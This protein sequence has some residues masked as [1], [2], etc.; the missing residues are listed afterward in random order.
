[1]QRPRQF[2]FVVA[3]LIGMASVALGATPA[4]ARTTRRPASSMFLT[5][6][7]AHHQWHMSTMRRQETQL[8]RLHSSL[9]HRVPFLGRA[10]DPMIGGNQRLHGWME[11]GDNSALAMHEGR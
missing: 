2:G 9:G 7:R 4:S 3:V 10:M 6:H 11:W 8:A 1:M 5:V